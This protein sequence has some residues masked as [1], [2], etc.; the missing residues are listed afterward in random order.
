MNRR[1]S[2]QIIMPKI[3][4][5]AARTPLMRKP[6]SYSVETMRSAS[7]S[8][9]GPPSSTPKNTERRDHSI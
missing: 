5:P 6:A 3:D 1:Y 8:R 4:A 2:S 9:T 7:A